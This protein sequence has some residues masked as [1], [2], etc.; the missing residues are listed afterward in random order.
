MRLSVIIPT[1]N[2]EAVIGRALSAV[3]SGQR[4]PDEV[5]V[6]DGLSSDDTFGKTRPFPVK[7]VANPKVHAAAARNLGIENST[8]E[9]IA[10]T[11]SDCVPR[12]DWLER[13]EE[14]F[15]NY[16]EIAGVG[17]RMLALPP[18]NEVEAFSS[19]VFL[20]EILRYPS[21]PHRVSDRALVGAFITANC[22]YRK[23]V[24]SE[25]G[26]FREEFGN[27]AEDIDLYWRLIGRVALYYDP[28][29]V[30]YHSFPATRAA[31]VRKYFQHGIASSKLTHYHLSGPRVDL[32][33]YRKLIANLWYLLD[34]RDQHDWATLY[35]LQLSAHLL[36]KVRGSIMMRT[37]NF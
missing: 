36:G 23:A 3:F 9:V 35:C 15:A 33:L 31:L 29:V 32:Q 7:W 25:A 37:L 28:E 16:P 19:H 6:V 11:D 8:G 21:I 17:G 13:I 20:N 18:A 2:S 12:S 10:F 1:F 30:V 22:A 27:N 24:L 5:I 14:H 26:G 4:V 34:L